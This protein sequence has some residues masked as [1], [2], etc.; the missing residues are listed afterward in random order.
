M[1]GQHILN[2]MYKSTASMVFSVLFLLLAGTLYWDAY[3]EL[4]W[5][6]LAISGLAYGV[7]K[8]Q[9][10][11]SSFLRLSNESALLDDTDDQD[12]Y[13]ILESKVNR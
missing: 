3:W 12:A 13:R 2:V 4:I 9:A 6:A 11:V 1:D 5:S 10:Y 8:K 7:A